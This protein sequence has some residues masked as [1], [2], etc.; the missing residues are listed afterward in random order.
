MDPACSCAVARFAN[1]NRKAK[2]A[3]RVALR[4]IFPPPS[5]QGL[6]EY[7]EVLG[8]RLWRIVIHL[9]RFSTQKLRRSSHPIFRTSQSTKLQSIGSNK[10]VCVQRKTGAIRP[11]F[12]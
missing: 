7:P 12:F 10:N 11:R 1:N 3:H 4:F 8:C 6:A 5:E 9:K 2:T